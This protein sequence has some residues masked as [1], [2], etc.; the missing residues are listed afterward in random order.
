[1]QTLALHVVNIYDERM[2]RGQNEFGCAPPAFPCCEILFLTDVPHAPFTL[3]AVFDGRRSDWPLVIAGTM[4]EGAHERA[5][6]K[7]IVLSSAF[8]F[9]FDMNGRFCDLLEESVPLGPL[10]GDAGCC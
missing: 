10:F 2:Q 6:V 5:A 9:A 7:R 4:L 3:T 8:P 1:M